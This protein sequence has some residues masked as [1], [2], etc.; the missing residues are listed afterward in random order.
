MRYALII[1]GGS[2][3]RLWP[4][5][6]R[7]LP[8]QLIPFIGGR[9]LLQIALDRLEGLL[10]AEQVYVC[11][12]ADHKQAIL[13]AVPTLD[14]SRFIAEPM[15]RDTLNAVGLGS[16]V[17]GRSDPEAVVAVFTADH[18]IE[19]M[20]DFQRTVA[21]G[22]ELAEQGQDTLVTFGIKPTYAATAY[23]YLQL[24][25]RIGEHGFKVDCFREKP[26]QDVAEQYFAAGPNKY[27]WNSGMFVWKAATLM[28]CIE[29]YAPENHASLKMVSDGWDM[30]WRQEMLS[31]VYPTLKKISVD[32]AV[33]EPAS[34]DPA[35]TVAAVPMDLRW[36]D[37]GSWPAFAATLA[38]D[39]AD[40]AAAGCNF[41]SHDS[42]NVL[43]VGD[44]PQHLVATLGCQDLIVIRTARATLV[45]RA[46]D[47][48]KIKDL[49]QRI[50]RQLGEE[51]L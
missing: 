46:A 44:D 32:F 13:E 27:L 10:P 36:L 51:W 47:A 1:A 45:C 38:R 25:Q 49:H 15:G 8:K 5:S 12:G 41:I 6:T 18:V 37:V 50:G 31:E 7:R 40:N 35:M 4:M 23:G 33:M 34:S 19:P 28:R 26:P 24:G 17:L 43:V 42:S 48:E 29:K 39:E 21:H 3:T 2:G 14:E 20:Q 11:A 22:F 9:S 30:P 16:A